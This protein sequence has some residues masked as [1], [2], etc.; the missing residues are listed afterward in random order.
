VA[1]QRRRGVGAEGREQ[2]LAR[3]EAGIA[4]T[5]SDGLIRRQVVMPVTICSRCWCSLITV[6]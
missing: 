6:T 1:A 5:G 3:R 2:Q 4:A